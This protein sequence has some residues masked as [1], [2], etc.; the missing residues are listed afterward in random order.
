LPT[1][2]AL[3]GGVGLAALMAFGL[4]PAAGAQPAGAPAAAEPAA[5]APDTASG[6]APAAGL[7]IYV[8][9]ETGEL[10][11]T[12]TPEQTERLS[13]ALAPLLERPVE[14]PVFFEIPGGGTGVFVGRRF[15]S[16]MVVRVRADGTFEL[17]CADPDHAHQMLAAPPSAAGSDAGSDAAAST[18][19]GSPAYAVK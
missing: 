8:D 14:E 6:A 17:G 12:P 7:R 3:W 9:P 1:F 19:A 4:P 2:P 10:T 5:A 11:S 16:A 13:A 15:A 18:T